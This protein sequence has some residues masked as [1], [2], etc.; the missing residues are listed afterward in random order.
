MYDFQNAILEM[1]KP[2]MPKPNVQPP[3]ARNLRY[4]RCVDCWKFFKDAIGNYVCREGIGGT[5][6]VW[7]TGERECVPLPDAWHYCSYYDGPQV[8]K[9]VIVCVKRAVNVEAMR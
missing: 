3:Q 9:D 6:V 4:C 1:P 2:V 7:T 5:M 8:S